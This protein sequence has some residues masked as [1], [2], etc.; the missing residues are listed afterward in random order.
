MELATVKRR[1]APTARDLGRLESARRRIAEAV[2]LP[3]PPS[4]P[5]IESESEAL[6]L[7]RSVCE[8]AAVLE[9]S[10]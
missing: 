5:F 4:N 2:N 8:L 3:D 7:A 9:A 10:R 1:K 6:T